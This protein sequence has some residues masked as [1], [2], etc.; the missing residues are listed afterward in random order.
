[1]ISEARLRDRREVQI[2]F[3]V[4]HE[5]FREIVAPIVPP[6]MVERSTGTFRT[7]ELMIGLSESLVA[8]LVDLEQAQAVGPVIGLFVHTVSR[9]AAAIGVFPAAG[10]ASNWWSQPYNKLAKNR[11]VLFLVVPVVEG[12]SG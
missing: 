2:A 7:P 6:S 1:M 5:S 10:A 4:S 11:D 3:A 12:L 9:R 8:D